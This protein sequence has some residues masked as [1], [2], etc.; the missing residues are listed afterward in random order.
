MYVSAGSAVVQKGRSL[1]TSLG[2]LRIATARVMFHK[3]NSRRAS[4]LFTRRMAR[5]YRACSV[6]VIFLLF[7]V[8]VTFSYLCFALSCLVHSVAR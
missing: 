3:V 1:R 6:R 7:S 2:A 5:R 4:G 8:R